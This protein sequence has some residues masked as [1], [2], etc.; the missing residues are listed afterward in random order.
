MRGSGF[1]AATTMSIWSAFATMMRS[2]SS[3]SSALRR[4]SVDAL[5]DP[6]DAGERAGL[7]GRVAD[8]VDVV[9]GHD[10]LAPELA[11]PRRGDLA[12][13]GAALV[14]EHRVA[15]AVDAEHRARDGVGV[16]GAG[17]VRGRLPRRL[18]RTRTSDSSNSCARPRR[19]PRSHQRHAE[20]L[21]PELRELRQGLRRSSRCRRPRRP[22]RRGRRSRPSWPC[23]GRRRRATARRAA[24]RARCAARRR[25]R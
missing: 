6:H 25:A 12:L 11:R 21:L 7:A 4:S 5:A 10:R 19:R 18:G 1:A 8:E 13:V 23:G 17:L 15:S 9:A 16:L 22:A 3:V 2:T 14:D 20:H 24:A